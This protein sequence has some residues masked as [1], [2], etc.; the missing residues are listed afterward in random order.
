MRGEL[1]KLG[2]R[3]KRERENTI[4][5]LTDKILKLESLHKQSLSERLA[6]D[7]LDT[8]KRLQQIMDATSKRFLFFKKKIYY[9]SGDKSG[10]FF[11]RALKG[12]RYRNTILGI[13]NKTG[14]LDVEDDLIAKHFRENYSTLYN[15]PRQHRPANTEEDRIHI[16]QTYLKTSKLPKLSETDMLALE[17]PIVAA[18]IKSA[19]Q[20]LRAG[21]SP[22]P[23]GFS[24]I[25]Y[26]T[27]AEI[28]LN[29]LTKA[30]NTFSSPREVPQSFL[31][32]HRRQTYG[33]DHSK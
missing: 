32:A 22:G 16:I 2:A 7:L 3:R 23:D 6:G 4:S 24:S 8:S 26:K 18:E 17:R 27:F 13:I 20:D 12:P 29:P 31:S 33:K 21:K 25:Y 15:L 9:E 28:L 10:K 30:L 19:I 5:D 14:S 11:A 1:I